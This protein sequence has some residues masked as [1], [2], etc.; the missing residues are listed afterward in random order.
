M[1]HFSKGVKEVLQI[2]FFCSFLEKMSEC[3][4]G[5]QPSPQRTTPMTT[6]SRS[7]PQQ[8]RN[9]RRVVTDDEDDPFAFDLAEYL[10]ETHEM[11]LCVDRSGIGGDDILDAEGV[12]KGH[13][14]RKD[15]VIASFLDSLGEIGKWNP[16]WD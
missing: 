10:I 1:T 11:G 6:R 4:N 7:S 12:T 14:K 8:S 13:Q 15:S 3:G 16:P 2:L 5:D 9:P